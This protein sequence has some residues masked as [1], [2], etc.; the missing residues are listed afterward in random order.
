MKFG[1]FVPCPE[2]RQAPGTEEELALS[3]AMTDHYF[4]IPTLEQ[5]GASIRQGQPP[6]LAPE[7]H[8]ELVEMIRD[9]GMLQRIQT[10]FSD[11]DQEPMLP[12]VDPPP[13][14]RWGKFW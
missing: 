6:K 14:K 9:S 3:L 4:D 2:C 10:M 12:Q 13:R 11:P 8:S 5:I 7:T 1:A